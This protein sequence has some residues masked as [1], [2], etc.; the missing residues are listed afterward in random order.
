MKQFILSL[1]IEKNYDRI[2]KGAC[3]AM[4]VIF[5]GMSAVLLPGIFNR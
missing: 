5:I 1:E 2:I 3:V 4:L